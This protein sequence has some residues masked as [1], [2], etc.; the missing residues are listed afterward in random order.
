MEYGTEA[1]RI[2]IHVYLRSTPRFFGCIVVNYCS[3]TSAVRTK[4]ASVR[5][6]LTVNDE[7]LFTR[8][9][10]PPQTSLPLL[11]RAFAPHSRPTSS[12]AANWH[13]P[14]FTVECSTPPPPPLRCTSPSVCV[15]YRACIREVGIFVLTRG[16]CLL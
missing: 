16:T 6:S 7:S 5:I 10:V 2:S 11:E 4:R 9:H 15:F 3:V 1:A 8:Q 13:G 12:D 14:L